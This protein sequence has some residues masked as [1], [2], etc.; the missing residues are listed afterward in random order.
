[1]TNYKYN[2][3]LNMTDIFMDFDF[4]FDP[5]S[6]QKAPAAMAYVVTNFGLKFKKPVLKGVAH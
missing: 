2:V 3:K 5:K 4:R 6:F 1:M